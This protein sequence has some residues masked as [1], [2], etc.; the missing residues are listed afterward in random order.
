[1]STAEV[2]R[3]VLLESALLGAISTVLGVIT[4]YVLS[5]ILIYVINKQSFGWTI[6]FHTPYRLIAGSLAATFV[7]SVMAGLLPS[8]L[9]NRINIAVSLKRE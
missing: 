8:R 1:M 5:L 7:A 6:A 3:M 2:R 9:A 4:G